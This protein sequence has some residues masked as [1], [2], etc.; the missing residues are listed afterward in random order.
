MP[1]P[2]PVP[3]PFVAGI[4]V[5]GRTVGEIE[6]R[7]GIAVKHSLDVAQRFQ[8]ADT[9]NPVAKWLQC[10]LRDRAQ[11]QLPAVAHLPD[12]LVDVASEGIALGRLLRSPPAFARRMFSQPK[13]L[14]LRDPVLFEPGQV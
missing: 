14:K 9:P 11:A 4:V 2:T 1:Q 3:V 5:G 7:S 8:I 12:A 10:F 6:K 13:A